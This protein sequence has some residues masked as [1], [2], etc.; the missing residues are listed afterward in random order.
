MV[1]IPTSATRG[2]RHSQ[3]HCHD[4]IVAMVELAHAE[5]LRLCGL[6]EEVADSLPASI[7]RHKCLMIASELEP[8]VRGIHRLEEEALF[9]TYRRALERQGKGSNSLERLI[10]E[11]VQDECFAGE[12][13]EALL[14]L[15]HD[16]TV[17]NPEAMGFM[18]RGFFEAKRRHVAFE[19]E[20]V[21]AEIRCQA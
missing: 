21:L 12:L 14:L 3:P 6:L 2:N 11:H 8:L 17:E 5:M 15:G 16:G 10:A 13:T 18:L 20:H 19:S 9:P 4:G 1:S 7:D